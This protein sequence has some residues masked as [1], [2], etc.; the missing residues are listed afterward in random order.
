MLGSGP[1]GARKESNNSLQHMFTW[2][3]TFV[4]GRSVGW[5]AAGMPIFEALRL[6]Q[7]IYAAQQLFELLGKVYWP[8]N[9]ILTYC[10][11]QCG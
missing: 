3:T 11:I 1:S 6:S 7:L 2:R 4:G 10:Q 8:E 5:L 9:R